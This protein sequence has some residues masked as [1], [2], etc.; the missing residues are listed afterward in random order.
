[1]VTD[2]DTLVLDGLVYRLHGID[3]P[4]TDQVCLNSDG[5]VWNC[6]IE[7]RDKVREFAGTGAVKCDTLGFDTK[8]RNRRIGLCSVDGAD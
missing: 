7:A 8:Y 2:V 5:V 1:M 6:G 3:A 4:E